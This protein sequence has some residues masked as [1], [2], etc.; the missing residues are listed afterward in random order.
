MLDWAGA[1]A[2]ERYPGDVRASMRRNFVTGPDG[3]LRL[4]HTPESLLALNRA[5][6]EQPQPPVAIYGRFRCPAMLVMATGGPFRPDDV[7]TIRTVNPALRVE[8]LACGHEVQAERPDEL[9]AL[10]A[11]ISPGR[12]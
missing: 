4:R 9:A 2:P 8:W 10:I 11:D 12:R 3:L 6:D 5:V 1:I 7:E